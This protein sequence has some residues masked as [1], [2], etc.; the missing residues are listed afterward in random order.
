MFTGPLIFDLPVEAATKAPPANSTK[1]AEVE[2]GGLYFQ[3]S[4]ILLDCCVGV[5]PS[6]IQLR[7]GCHQS[8]QVRTWCGGLN[9]IAQ[10]CLGAVNGWSETDCTRWPASYVRPPA[11]V[12]HG[13]CLLP[14]SDHWP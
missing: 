3:A 14:S 2:T 8:R 10:L 6:F 13:S 1:G 7:L 4:D 9:S 12:S 11:V 5:R